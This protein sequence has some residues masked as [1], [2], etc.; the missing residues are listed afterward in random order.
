M[1]AEPNTDN[2]VQQWC[3]RQV[4]YKPLAEN[5]AGLGEEEA[6]YSQCLAVTEVGTAA[7]SG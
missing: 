5:I 7:H 4:G 6:L 3:A 2:L 1:P